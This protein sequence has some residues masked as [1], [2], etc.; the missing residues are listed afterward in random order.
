[1]TQSQELLC[2]TYPTLPSSLFA[3]SMEKKCQKNQRPEAESSSRPAPPFPSTMN[4]AILPVQLH[5][6]GAD[7]LSLIQRAGLAFSLV[8]YG[9]H[10]Y[11]CVY[12]LHTHVSV[13]I[14]CLRV[15]AKAARCP[16]F[17][18]WLLATRNI[19]LPSPDATLP[20]IYWQRENWH[21][22]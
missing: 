20:R 3:L 11:V 14:F 22:I 4:A 5:C 9:T 21:S 12:L 2:V 17:P 18:L 19:P 6:K 1:M 13:C 16:L 7:L 15:F 8:S 10:M